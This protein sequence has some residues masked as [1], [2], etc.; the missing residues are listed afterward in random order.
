MRATEVGDLLA[1]M[2]PAERAEVGKIIASDRAIWRPQPG[3][4][5][6]AYNSKADVIGY[7]GSAGGGKTD[8]GCGLAL[9]KHSVSAIF[10]RQGTEMT[11]IIDR[12]VQLVGNRNGYNGNEHIW[13]K[14]PGGRQVEF[15]SVPNVGDEAKYQGRAKDLLVIDEA[16]NFLESQV[17]FLMGWVR[18][19][20]AGQKCTVLLTFNP[21]TTAEGRWLIAFFAP[22]LDPKHPNPAL[23]GELRWFATLDGH[24]V[25]VESGEPFTHGEELIRPQ[26]RTFIPS[27]LDDNPFLASTGY[28]AVLQSLPE[29]LRSQMLLGDFSA[30]MEDDRWQV[31]PTAWVDAAM[32]RWTPK[33]PKG[34]MDSIGVDVARGGKDKTIIARRHGTWFDELLCYPG[35]D[36]PD[37]PSVA[38][39]VVTSRRDIAPVH[40]DIIGVGGSAFDFLVANGVHVLPINNA[41]TGIKTRTA[42][43]T[44]GFFNKRA[45]LLWRVREA[46]DPMSADPIA[47][48]ND[49]TLKADLC[50]PRWWLKP[51]GIQVESKE[52]IIK[53]IRRSPDR[54]DAVVMALIATPKDT[55][56][57]A[58]PPRNVGSGGWM[59]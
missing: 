18:S 19:T 6:D 31:I 26:S 5:S 56:P 32:A 39:L 16:A 12:L 30:G 10:R 47:L 4:Q 24:E 45:E 8:L 13:R 55:P 57:P 36:T 14:L 29:P 53:R 40:I 2:T 27:R 23:P 20:K 11:A 48:P 58:A 50:A 7:G 42:D 41:L 15:G 22:W 54:G 28:R 59:S 37:G 1:W 38:G 25:E 3:P 43:G 51:V 46:L 35:K 9:T 49:S 21:P 17:R 34:P 33:A 44:L 52:E